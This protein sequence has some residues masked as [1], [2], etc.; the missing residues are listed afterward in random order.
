MT[1]AN[2]DF[3]NYMFD[4]VIFWFARSEII[5]FDVESRYLIVQN[6]HLVDRKARGIV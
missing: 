4:I 3:F 5:I 2:F 1:I 6:W